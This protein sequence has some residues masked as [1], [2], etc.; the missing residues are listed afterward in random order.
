MSERL[1]E[2]QLDQGWAE[3][4]FHSSPACGQCGGRELPGSMLPPG[5]SDNDP[6]FDLPSQPRSGRRTVKIPPAP[7]TTMVW[8]TPGQHW[9]KTKA[10]NPYWETERLQTCAEHQSKENAK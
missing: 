10:A 7:E 8:C 1:Y 2:R 5:C 4:C 6:Y 3:D 9:W